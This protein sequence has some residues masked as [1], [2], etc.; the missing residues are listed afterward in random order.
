MP[1]T[2]TIG[3]MWLKMAWSTRSNAL[4]ISM[5]HTLTSDPES[6]ARTQSSTTEMSCQ[7][8]DICGRKPNCSSGIGCIF[9]QCA[10]SWSFTRLSKIFETHGNRISCNGNPVGVRGQRGDRKIQG[11]QKMGIKRGPQE[12]AS[13]AITAGP[14]QHD[15]TGPRHRAFDVFQGSCYTFLPPSARHPAWASKPS[16]AT[17]VTRWFDS[18]FMALFTLCLVRSCGTCARVRYV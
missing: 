15:T 7:T 18:Y 13:C 10:W 1:L 2:S 16:S 4:A 11:R 17:S 14:P 6:S 5:K 3:R 12:L 8:V 9:R